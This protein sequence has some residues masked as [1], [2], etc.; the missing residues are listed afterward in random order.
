MACTCGLGH[1]CQ[2]LKPG[3]W[4]YQPVS[5]QWAVAMASVVEVLR[6]YAV[7]ME[8]GEVPM[9]PAPLALLRVAGVIENTPRTTPMQDMSDEDWESFI[10]KRGP[11]GSQPIGFA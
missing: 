7:M 5:D 2:P 1:E 10:Q 11:Q 3:C 8:N 9:L 6:G 4:G